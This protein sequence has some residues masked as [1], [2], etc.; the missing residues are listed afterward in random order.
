MHEVAK[1]AC[2]REKKL[3]DEMALEST[4]SINMDGLGGFIRQ[5]HLQNSSY[6][7]SSRNSHRSQPPRRTSYGKSL[8]PESRRGPRPKASPFQSRLATS[9]GVYKQGQRTK[10]AQRSLIFKTSSGSSMSRAPTSQQHRRSIGNESDLSSRGDTTSRIDQMLRQ[11][12]QKTQKSRPMWTV[13]KK[14]PAALFQV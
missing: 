9:I 10:A 1:N 5:R 4:C 12:L 13:Y 11:L 6:R 2:V 14:S 8:S 3:I 7:Q